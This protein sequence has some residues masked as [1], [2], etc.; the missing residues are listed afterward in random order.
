MAFAAKVCFFTIEIST[1]RIALGAAVP[2]IHQN[3][4]WAAAVVAMVIPQGRHDQW[5][6]IY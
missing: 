5:H 1:S 3:V 6:L 2:F 4:D